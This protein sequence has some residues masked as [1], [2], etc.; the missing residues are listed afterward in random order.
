[1]KKRILVSTV[2]SVLL[3]AALA[4]NVHAAEVK[5]TASDGAEED[6]FGASV[7]ISGDL[8]I[9]GADRDDDAGSY[10]GSVYIFKRDGTAWTEQA[11]I[12]A[13]DGA[14]GDWFRF[15]KIGNDFLKPFLFRRQS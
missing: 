3:L 15:R 14:A 2:L 12:T 5:I 13:S 9:V 10:S 7:A 8:A 1:M 11:K 6:H 4:V